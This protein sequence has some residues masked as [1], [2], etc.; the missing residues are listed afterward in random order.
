MRQRQLDDP[1]VQNTKSFDWSVPPSKGPSI[2]MSDESINIAE[3]RD[4]RAV[5]QIDGDVF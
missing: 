4:K 2:V 5:D 1:E 3:A